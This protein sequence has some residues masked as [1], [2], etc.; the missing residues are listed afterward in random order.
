MSVDYDKRKLFIFWPYYNL[1]LITLPSENHSSLKEALTERWR[2][3]G[4]IKGGLRIHSLPLQV[5]RT[6][7]IEAEKNRL[8]RNTTQY[9]LVELKISFGT[10]F[11]RKLL[12][13]SLYS[14]LL[15][16]FRLV[17]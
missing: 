11:Y 14:S 1:K 8:F 6:D 16:C 3:G 12:F 17:G 9:R 7:H 5:L 10:V 2:K 15:H 4:M 13:Y